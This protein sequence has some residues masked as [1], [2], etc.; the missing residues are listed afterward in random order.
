VY[1][2][3]GR[4]E[5]ALFHALRC[6]DVCNENGLE[7]FVPASAHEALARAYAVLGD[8]EQAQVE[9]NLAYQLAVALDD[10]DDR[11][12]IESDLATLPL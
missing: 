10:D 3:L 7:S 11:A 2:V 4:G 1:A 9:R 5:P 8:V 12:V 6:L